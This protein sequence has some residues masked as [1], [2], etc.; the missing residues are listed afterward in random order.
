[1][2][3]GA[4]G[5]AKSTVF[6]SLFALWGSLG[7]KNRCNYKL[8]RPLGLVSSRTVC[9][10]LSD[11]GPGSRPPEVRASRLPE[12]PAIGPQA[13]SDRLTSRR[14]RRGTSGGSSRG[15]RRGPR[16]YSASSSGPRLIELYT[17]CRTALR[18]SSPSSSSTPAL[19]SQPAIPPA[20]QAG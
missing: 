20:S 6:I 15:A 17:S 19:S 2:P 9:I 18:P 8:I 14:A 5:V 10:I 4:H 16:S 12:L 1:M 3:F 13:L 11:F 7:C